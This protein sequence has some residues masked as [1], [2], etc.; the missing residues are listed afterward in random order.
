MTQRPPGGRATARLAALALFCALTGACA[1]R[2]A[3]P[4]FPPTSAASTAAIEAEPAAVTRALEDE[5]ALTI[6]TS[7]STPAA[8]PHAGHRGGHHAP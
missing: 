7:S 3:S 2:A 4:S 5:P 1:G 8:D 6:P